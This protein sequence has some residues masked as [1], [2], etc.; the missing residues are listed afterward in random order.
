M[1]H[2]ALKGASHPL[3]ILP[4]HLHIPSQ[5]SSRQTSFSQIH[6][7]SPRWPFLKPSQA[8][9]RQ[10]QTTFMT[11]SGFIKVCPTA[12]T[13]SHTHIS[14]AATER[15]IQSLAVQRNP[16][17]PTQERPSPK[18]QPSTS[19]LASK[20]TN[21]TKKTTKPATPIRGHHQ[22]VHP[23]VQLSMIPPPKRGDKTPLDVAMGLA[24]PGRYKTYIQI[25]VRSNSLHFSVLEMALMVYL[26]AYSEDFAQC[27]ARLVKAMA[28]GP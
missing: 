17:Q 9:H 21:N 22:P 3:A 10:I 11:N 5:L 1:R 18:P 23:S 7:L 12:L 16:E 13:A 2:T 8:S 26:G 4:L 14:T 20:R 28:R 27:W 24:G 19:R 6:N 25:R 15:L